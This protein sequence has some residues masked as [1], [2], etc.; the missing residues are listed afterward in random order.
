MQ[1][2]YRIATLV[3]KDLNHI[4]QRTYRLFYNGLNTQNGNRLVRA[5]RELTSIEKQRYGKYRSLRFVKGTNEPIYP[6]GIVQFKNPMAFNQK[7]SLY[8]PQGREK[9]HQYLS[10]DLH[11]LGQL[12]TY[13]PKGQSIEYFDN[14]ISLYSMQNGKCYVLGK[15]FKTTAEI[16]CHHKKSR[17]SGGTDE[18]NNLVLIHEDI[19][20]LIHAKRK[21]T[22]E[23]YL[24]ILSLNAEQLRKTNR[25][26][27]AQGLPI[28][29][30]YNKKEHLLVLKNV[31]NYLDI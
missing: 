29:K 31:E 10:Q 26:R 27:F 21:E 15:S 30:E 17:M 4:Q 25:L 16:H 24:E 14:R 2:Y 8:T 3:S 19:H 20:K 7:L 6:I 12:R 18:F 11:L 5:G 22:I 28:I 13:Y 9:I 1:N 23:R